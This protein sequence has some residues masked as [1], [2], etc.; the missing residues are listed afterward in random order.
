MADSEGEVSDPLGRVTNPERFAVLHEEVDRLV[1]ELVA[2]YDVVRTDGVGLDP[3]VSPDW[4][5]DPAARL[6]PVGGG[7]PLVITRTGF[8][9]VMVGFGHHGHEVFPRCGCDG[10][11]E[12][13]AEERRRLAE[14]VAE[15]V[16]GGRSE[17][18]VYP[19]PTRW[20]HLLWRLR[21]PGEVTEWTPWVRRGDQLVD[22]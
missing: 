20:S 21:G 2:E 19:R 9:G 13:P 1:D 16:A 5:G 14:V 11:D 3:R 17:P 22:P 12:D 4:S 15:V 8:P 6:E 18:V 7:S 10:C